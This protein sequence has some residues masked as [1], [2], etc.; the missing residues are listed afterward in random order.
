[1]CQIFATCYNTLSILT[2]YGH[3]WYNDLIFFYS[4][5]SLLSLH[6]IRFSS[7]SFFLRH[8]ASP[9]FSSFTL[10]S[11]QSRCFSLF[12][13]NITLS[14]FFLLFSSFTPITVAMVVFLFFGS[15]LILGLAV[16]ELRL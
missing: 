11:S 7:L 9:F 5:F 10:F 13:S 2:W 8:Q 16:G 4:L 1:M 12:L 3:K 15:N 14:F 6:F